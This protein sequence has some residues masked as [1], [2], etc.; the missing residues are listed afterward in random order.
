MKKIS[1]LFCLLLL[2]IIPILKCPAQYEKSFNAV[3]RGDI[4]N[5]KLSLVFTAIEYA[6]GADEI[7]SVLNRKKHKG[8]FLSDRGLFQ[9]S[10]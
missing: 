7:L 2:F 9:K 6:E 5:K 10:Y 1:F 8:S 4:F 3:I